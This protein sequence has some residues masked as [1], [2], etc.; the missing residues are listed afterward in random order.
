MAETKLAQ[1]VILSE[2]IDSDDEK[3]RRGK[4]RKW[5]KRRGSHGYY[6][7]LIQEFKVKDLAGF[8]RMFRMT[9]TDFEHILMHI[10]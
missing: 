10:G 1:L 8:R 2:L 6:N 3:E 9:A 4:T 7:N 5:I